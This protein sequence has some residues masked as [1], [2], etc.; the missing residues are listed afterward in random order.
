MG[1]SEGGTN[2]APPKLQG[3]V[4]ERDF[5]PAPTGLE[6][7]LKERGSNYGKFKDHAI[8]TWGIKIQMHEAILKNSRQFTSAQLEALDMIAHKIG[9][10]VNGDPNYVD[11]WT[12][13]AGYARLIEKELTGDSV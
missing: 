5:G 13:I 11:S 7:T 1:S 3:T 8:T 12:D 9:R 10:I 2:L 4:E 6:E